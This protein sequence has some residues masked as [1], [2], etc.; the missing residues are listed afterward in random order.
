MFVCSAGQCVCVCM[1][2]FGRGEG[3]ERE[4]LQSM[5]R[6]QQSTATVFSSWGIFPSVLSSA[7]EMY[8]QSD[9]GQVI[10]LAIA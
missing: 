5:A 3:G 7:S 4:C 10:D 2:V 8:A 9:S 6:V 1:R